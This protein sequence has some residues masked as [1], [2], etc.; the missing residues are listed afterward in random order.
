M[1]PQTI[2]PKQK[3]M[4]D[5]TTIWHQSSTVPKWQWPALLCDHME[6][7]TPWSFLEHTND[8]IKRNNKQN[9]AGIICKRIKRLQ[10]PSS[11]KIKTLTPRTDWTLAS[12][13]HLT[14]SSFRVGC[15]TKVIRLKR[16]WNHGHIQVFITTGKKDM[17]PPNL[18]K[19]WNTWLFIEFLW[20]YHLPSHQLCKGSDAFIRFSHRSLI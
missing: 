1:M 3:Q 10:I 5:C 12:P 14:I 6:T 20:Q 2:S 17:C 15:A 13:F 18:T 16:E 19:T 7:I 8:Y 9:L 4:W 11:S